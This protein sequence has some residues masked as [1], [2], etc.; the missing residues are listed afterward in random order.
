MLQLFLLFP[1]VDLFSIQNV[2]AGREKVENLSPGIN[3]DTVCNPS[4]DP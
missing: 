1:R 2:V 3:A 4:S